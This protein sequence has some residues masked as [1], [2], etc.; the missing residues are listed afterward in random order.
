MDSC[1]M[2]IRDSF[3]R[4]KVAKT[5]KSIEIQKARSIMI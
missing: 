1:A 4:I 5:V 3:P 2:D